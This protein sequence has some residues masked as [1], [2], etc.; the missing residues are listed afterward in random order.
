MRK[1][2]EWTALWDLRFRDNDDALR[3][4]AKLLRGGQADQYFL[5]LLA[6]HIDPDCNSRTRVK[7]IPVRTNGSGPPP[8]KNNLALEEF[9]E[10][11]IDVFEE[12]VEAVFAEAKE[13]FG[14]SRSKCAR[15]LKRVR[16]RRRDNPELRDLM[17]ISALEL[18]D[19]GDPD[20]Q[21]ISGMSH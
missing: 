16:E 20:Y 7:L 15:V 13:R 9:L 21:P 12:K 18:R 6:E 17:R 3:D 8:A 14:A 1:G 11:Q 19:L 5:D 10:V 4:I 2:L